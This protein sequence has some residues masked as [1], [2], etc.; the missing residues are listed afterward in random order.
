[1]LKSVLSDIRLAWHK[2]T[3]NKI[4]LI[5]IA[6]FLVMK[7]LFLFPFYQSV[8]YG[9]SLSDKLWHNLTHPWNWISHMFLH[10][11]LFHIL[12][13][14]L[15]LYWFGRILGDFLGD[16]KVL[17]TY[18]LSGLGGGLTFVAFGTLFSQGPVGAFALGASAAVM[19]ILWAT[20]VLVPDYTINLLFFGPVKIKW[21]ALALFVLDLI[22][23]T[24]QSN[25]GGHVAHIGG[26]LTGALLIY[27]L[28]SGYDILSPT[29]N[30]LNQLM[31]WLSLRPKKNKSPLTLVHRSNKKQSQNSAQP[32]EAKLDAILEKI[33]K[34]GYDSLTIQE[35]EFLRQASENS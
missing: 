12:F 3:L 4:I 24:S 30:R 35:K 16:N 22:G 6:V 7:I 17:P 9:L 26:A 31:H 27:L 18:I 1:M 21:I 10:E 29:N 28:K 5:N 32:F 14:M 8:L 11:G 25:T 19:G 34:S 15:Y 2:H 13:N 20:A 33:K 23:V